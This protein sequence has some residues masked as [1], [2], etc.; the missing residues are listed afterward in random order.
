M[1]ATGDLVEI[2]IA[3]LYTHDLATVFLKIIQLLIV[4]VHHL[5]DMHKI[6]R[7]AFLGNIKK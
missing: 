6:L 5:R 1:Q 3:G 2:T 4:R 7:R